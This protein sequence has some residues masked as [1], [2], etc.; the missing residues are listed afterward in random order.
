MKFIDP[1]GLTTLDDFYYQKVINAEIQEEK[2]TYLQKQTQFWARN[3]GSSEYGKIVKKF[4]DFSEIKFTK[5]NPLR[6]EELDKVLGYNRKIAKTTS[7]MIAA[8]INAYSSL[9]K[10]GIT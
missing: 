6:Q 2:E 10:T 4:H 8:M 3:Q 1:N 5:M 7:C 9:F